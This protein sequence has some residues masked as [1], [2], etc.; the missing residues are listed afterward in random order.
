LN[1]LRAA[2]DLYRQKIAKLETQ[3]ADERFGLEMTQKLLRN[4]EVEIA[5]LEK[6]SVSTT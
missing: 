6:Q 2:A 4:V 3:P 5:S 1:E